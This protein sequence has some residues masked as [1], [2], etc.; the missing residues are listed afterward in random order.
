MRL[1]VRVVVGLV[2]LVIAGEAWALGGPKHVSATPSGDARPMTCTLHGKNLPMTRADAQGFVE[3]DGYVAMEAADTTA[4][5]ADAGGGINWVEL[6]GYSGTKSAITMFPVTPPSE[7]NSKT[8]LEYRMYLYDS[9][10]FDVEMVLG[11]TL[12][13]VVVEGLVV[14]DRALKP[15]YPGPPESFHAQTRAGG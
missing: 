14:S 10:K 12:N 8:A 7:T 4:R 9:G 5:T 3:S 13:F 6:P 11:P 15:S 1:S 2:L